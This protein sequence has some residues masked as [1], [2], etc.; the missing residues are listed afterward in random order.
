MALFYDVTTPTEMDMLVGIYDLTGYMRFT[1]ELDPGA[2]FD[3]M[4]GYFE[5]TGNMLE[6]AGGWLVK[7]IGDAGLAAFSAEQTD[8]GVAAFLELKRQGDDWLRSQGINSRAV[9][10]LHLGPVACGAVRAPGLSSAA[11]SMHRERS[12]W[13]STV[14]RLTSRRPWNQNPSQFRP[15]RFAVLARKAGRRLRSIRHRSPIS[16]P[17]TSISGAGLVFCPPAEH[18]EPM[19]GLAIPFSMWQCA[20]HGDAAGPGFVR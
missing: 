15:R 20:G 10:K 5:F 1:R 3:L 9:K 6:R 13:I 16:G 12:A 14:I 17:R 7:S 8:S 11:P 19:S 4:A 18:R 2:I